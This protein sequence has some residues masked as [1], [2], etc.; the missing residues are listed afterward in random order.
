[1]SNSV[2]KTLNKGYYGIY[3][4]IISS[5]LCLCQNYQ[6]LQIWSC[7]VLDKLSS[8]SLFAM[9]DMHFHDGVFLFGESHYL[10]LIKFI[11]AK[12]CNIRLKDY[13]KKFYWKTL[14]KGQQSS[15]MY[16]N[17]MVLFQGR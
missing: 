9:F 12:Y 6:T 3:E 8:S 2:K 13:A 11:T 1:M 15:R 10:Q 5:E 16:L 17:K 4:A 7:E 14:F